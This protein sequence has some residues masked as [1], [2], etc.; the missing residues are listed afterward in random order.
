MS[1]DIGSAGVILRR[2]DTYL[3]LKQNASGKWGPPKGHKEDVDGNKP[4][5]TAARE[6]KEE[7]G[8]IVTPA[9]MRRSTFMK[10]KDSKYY[11]YL[12]DVNANEKHITIPKELKSVN[13][14]EVGDY[15][16]LTK[17]EA[18]KKDLNAWGKFVSNCKVF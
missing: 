18:S 7:T 16:W 6:L 11:V 3:F 12:I 2:G 9:A 1:I 14:G 17:E 4:A 8:I 13:S 10:V 5:N 15:A